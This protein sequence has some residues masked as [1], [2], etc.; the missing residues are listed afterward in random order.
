[1]MKTEHFNFVKRSA[2][3]VHAHLP[4]PL[5]MGKHT[6]PD[7]GAAHCIQRSLLHCLFHISPFPKKEQKET[8]FNNREE[9]LVTVHELV[10][11]LGANL[12]NSS[13]ENK[14]LTRSLGASVISSHSGLQNSYFPSMMLR[15]ITICFLC[16][17]GGKPTSLGTQNKAHVSL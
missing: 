12:S 16:Q 8:N 1:M 6:K 10:R 13:R 7:N 5:F 11:H 2:V 17:N 4:I 9:S 14:F 3:P 15:S